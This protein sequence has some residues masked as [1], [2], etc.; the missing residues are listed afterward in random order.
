MLTIAIF[1]GTVSLS[2]MISTVWT[3]RSDFF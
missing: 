2:D 1:S 3:N